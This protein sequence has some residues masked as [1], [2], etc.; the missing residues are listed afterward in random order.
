MA[1]PWS[2]ALAFL[3]AN[4]ALSH[5]AEPGAPHGKRRQ[6][7]A[8]AAGGVNGLQQPL[9][10]PQ[11]Y[12]RDRG[13]QGGQGARAGK[14]GAGLLAHGPPRPPAGPEDDGT[15]LEGLGPVR[16]ETGPGGDRDRV[17]MGARGPSQP[18][19]NQL[20]GTRKGRGHGH[21]PHPDH[22]RQGGRRDRG[23]HGKGESGS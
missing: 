14:G 1:L 13:G 22:R 15:G 23:G 4:L 7:A 20:L 12:G 10:G 5:G 6:A 8:V 17:R 19:E 3:L 21:G 11:G 16:L 18:R 2:L 9:R